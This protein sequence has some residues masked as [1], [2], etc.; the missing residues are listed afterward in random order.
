MPTG[1]MYGKYGNIYHQQKNQMLAS[2]YH[3]YGSVM[4]YGMLYNSI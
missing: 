4:G 2:I 3:T 1:S